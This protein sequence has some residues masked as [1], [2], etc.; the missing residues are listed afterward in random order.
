MRE[1]GLWTPKYHSTLAP[2]M[3]RFIAEKR[4]GGYRYETGA[5]YLHQFDNFL[6]ERNHKTSALSKDV[7]EAWTARRE[8]ECSKTQMARVQALKQFA[9]FLIRNEVPAYLLPKCSLPVVR[10]T[11]MPYIFT[12]EQMGDIFA[13]LDRM[14][15]D[16]RSPRRHI[17]MP[18]IFRVLYGCGLRL[19]EA[20]KLL[21]RDVD[22]VNGVL[23]VRDTKFGKDRLVPMVSSL[24]Q[25]LRHYA[26]RMGVRDDDAYFFPAPDEG[27][28]HQFTIYSL[29]RTILTRLGI[30][31]DSK[32]PGIRVHDLRHT[33][34]IT[35]LKRW[36][37][38]GACLNA[39][40]PVLSTYLGHRK[41]EA[42]QR[43]LKWLPAIFPEIAAT[44][45]SMTG[46]VIPRRRDR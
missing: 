9:K 8:N 27:R 3:R 39:K 41:L 13:A 36:Y 44:M 20:L 43:Y 14:T 31:R 19:R 25:R 4:A 42:T 6:K 30:A 2:W 37:Q 7:V 18:E 22:L 38:E 5:Y 40:L 45:E 1:K 34:A 26:E 12:L 33:M 46:S 28:Y 21:V 15:P 10:D 24:T 11:F 29:F 32:R 23:K 35:C 16:Q 17:I